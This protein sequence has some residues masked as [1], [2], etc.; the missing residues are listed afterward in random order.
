MEK[1]KHK[2]KTDM[3]CAYLQENRERNQRKLTENKVSGSNIVY[4]ETSQGTELDNV[5]FN[6]NTDTL[7][8][9]LLHH[10]GHWCEEE[11]EK[12][13]KH[14]SD[15]VH[16]ATCSCK[17]KTKN[18]YESTGCDFK[19]KRTNVNSITGEEDDVLVDSS[20]NN[21]QEYIEISDSHEET[22]TDDTSC[23]PM[24]SCCR[25]SRQRNCYNTPSV[26]T[27][28]HSPSTRPVLFGDYLK[29]SQ[30]SSVSSNY[31]GSMQTSCS[32]ITTSD[33]SSR[34]FS[35]N[36]SSVNIS[37][38]SGFEEEPPCLLNLV[39]LDHKCKGFQSCRKTKYRNLNVHLKHLISCMP[40]S[41][42][43]SP[44]ENTKYNNLQKTPPYLSRRRHAICETSEEM[45]TIFCEALNSFLT[46]QAMVKYDFL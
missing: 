28:V 5:P 46:L 13:N 39:F 37:Q 38:D 20:I 18:T 35:S 2:E 16:N 12:E 15:T 34:T 33:M 1:P 17:T 11:S 25:K 10:A 7:C 27:D 32:M 42:S 9:C 22:V 21:K 45:R 4:G 8:E 44:R 14:F 3:G 26:H 19:G 41:F 29:I 6:N 30:T 36:G 40:Q 43:D 24:F 23:F 31:S